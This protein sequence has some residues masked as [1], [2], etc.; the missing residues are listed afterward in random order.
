MYYYHGCVFSQIE[1][2]L[3]IHKVSTGCFLESSLTQC[4]AFHFGC[5]VIC[6]LCSAPLSGDLFYT[7]KWYQTYQS[8][9][10]K[11]C[12]STTKKRKSRMFG[13]MIVALSPVSRQEFNDLETCSTLNVA[14]DLERSHACCQ[15]NHLLS[16]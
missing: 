14:N 2:I 7:V 15:V 16:G 4:F 10:S 3:G 11:S 5:S 12:L 6:F 1:I 8:Y 13:V 9:Q